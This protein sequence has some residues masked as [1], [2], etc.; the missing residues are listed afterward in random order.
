MK[1]LQ[2]WFIIEIIH[3][4]LGG[5]GCLIFPEL[6]FN[7]YNLIE[8]ADDRTIIPFVIMLGAFYVEMIFMSFVSY[9]NIIVASKFSIGL[10]CFYFLL[11]LIDVKDF[12]KVTYKYNKLR[13]IYA[14]VNFTFGIINFVIACELN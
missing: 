10:F 2:Y 9:V 4:I 8:N 1:S 7:S 6:I 3:F 13:W 12:C 5:I 11:F 14:F